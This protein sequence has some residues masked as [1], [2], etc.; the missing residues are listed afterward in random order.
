MSVG[1]DTGVFVRLLSKDETA[2]RLWE[3]ATE[4]N[5][6]AFTSALSVFELVL[7]LPRQS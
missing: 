2:I 1:F 5:I 7:G 6:V 3:E 4:N